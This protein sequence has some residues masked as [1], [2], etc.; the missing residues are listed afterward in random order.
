MLCNSGKYKTDYEYVRKVV[1]PTGLERV[2]MHET[3]NYVCMCVCV[4][5][6]LVPVIAIH[7][8]FCAHAFL[9]YTNRSKIWKMCACNACVLGRDLFFF[10]V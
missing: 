3:G 10:V 2:V 1:I 6:L 7:A 8:Q 9:S 5:W 4:C